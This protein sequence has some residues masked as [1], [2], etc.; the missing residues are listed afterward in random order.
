MTEKE[1]KT[2]KKTP[3]RHR[4]RK[5]FLYSGILLL[6][7]LTGAGAGIWWLTQTGSG[8]KWLMEKVNSMLAPK[9]GEAG[10]NIRLTGLSGSLPFNFRTSLEILDEKGVWLEAPEIVFSLNWHELPKIIHIQALRLDHVDFMRFPE[11]NAEEEEKKPS[12]PFTMEDLQ[13][14]LEKITDFLNTE[15]WWLP[16]IKLENTGLANLQLPSGILPQEGEKRLSLNMEIGAAFKQ[17]Q[18]DADVTLNIKTA[19][20]DAIALPQIELDG[21]NA[22]LGLDIKPEN[23]GLLATSALNIEVLKP[24]LHVA[25]LPP[26]FIGKTS[27]LDLG[28][29]VAASDLK[30]A[31]RLDMA[32]KGPMLTAGNAD[33]SA[34]G[35]WEKNLKTPDIDGPLKYELNAA[36]K[37]LAAGLEPASPLEIIKAP[38]HVHLLLNGNLPEAALELKADCAELARDGHSLKDLTISV[39]TEPVK[40]PLNE[41]GLAALENENKIRVTL[42]A[43]A[44]NN[45]IR[46]A[47][48]LFF[49]ALPK[50]SGWKAGLHD[51]SLDALGMTAAGKLAALLE[52]EKKPAIS[53]NINLNIVNWNVINMFVPDYRLSGKV[54]LDAN[55][56]YSADPAKP[57][58]ANSQNAQV[59]LEVPELALRSN[60][61]S[62]IEIQGLGVNASLADLFGAP[63]FDCALTLRNVKAA[64][65]N[66]GAKI[67]ANGPI[68]G[69]I[70]ADIATSGNVVSRI[71]AKW[72]QGSV[73]ISTLNV[74]AQLP[75]FGKK[76]LGI[77]SRS[78]FSVSYGEKGIQ[79]NG[80]DVSVIPSGRL[81]ADGSLSPVKLD[82]KIR[83]SALDF[84]PWQAL[85]P[86]IPSGSADISVDLS[87][88]PARPSGNFSLK[89]VK[90]K[91]PGV[92]IAPVGATLAGNIENA[93]S[94]SALKINLDI[95]KSTLKTL[96]S[97]GANV[98]GRIPLI[99][100]ADGIPKPDMN[101]PLEAKIRWDGALGPIW[102]LLPIPDRRLNGRIAINIDAGGTLST[103][104]VKGGVKI[105]RARYEDLL[106]GVLLTDINL[107]LNL[108]E[109]GSISRIKEGGGIP[110]KMELAL[111]ASDGRKGSI[112][113]NG[114]GA[115]TGQDL[116]IRAKIDHLK[117]LRRRDI[118][119]ELSGDARVTGTAF[120]PDVT[121]EIVVNQGEVLLNNIDFAGSV[122]TLNITTP[123]ELKKI[124]A[125]TQAVAPKKSEKGTGS[126]N[127]RINMLPRFV[128]E[129]RGL[130]STWRANMRVEGALT[131][132]KILGNISSVQGNFDFLGKVFTLTRGIVFFGGGS[133]S[134][135]L[136]DIELT[137]DAPDLVAHILITGPVDK[138]KLTLTSEPQLPRDEILS[139]VL[140]GKSINDLSRLEMLQLAAAVAQLAGFGSTGGIL[141]SAKKALGVDVLRIGSS[142]GSE[143]E[144]GE[145]TAEGTTI[146]MGKYIN[147]MIYMGVQQGLNPDST[148]FIIQI[149]LTPRTSLEIKTEHN[150]TS[151][152]IKWK[153]NY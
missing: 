62:P 152:G 55:L 73:D 49:Q 111:S 144:P 27:T 92:Q 18:A 105:E 66:I 14:L 138:I 74:E 116:D 75:D 16:E 72:E 80:L 122:T 151:G 5:F 24:V 130:T 149:E 9:A 98:S 58:T 114:T 123:E 81:K 8:H 22:R 65:M 64:G 25:G 10:I 133:P 67:N 31:P 104:R 95:D 124:K 150:N 128:V 117:P 137:N 79:I 132:P 83:L 47:S 106:L 28:M 41:A 17:P 107:A 4:I 134:N 115:L 59:L 1:E 145:E 113:V 77:R 109:N 110:G 103:P 38:L 153:Y 93:G 99:F 21:I 97:N 51:L 129:G 140:F 71:T 139:A 57:Q 13:S 46:L 26:D 37:P 91:V 7:T 3:K 36:L 135:P 87:G 136:L 148:A 29:A 142:S 112:S 70:S 121:G 86:Q 15:H 53:G 48:D 20:G 60:N 96:G 120:A 131:D 35:S 90:V 39:A 101:A 108:T 119:I 147:D 85:V 127:V 143:G 125:E 100:G 63:G 82:L 88:T 34:E 44:D 42:D 146:E 69:P 54:K 126:L 84:K 102:N 12:E 68:S 2:E 43:S 56:D 52:K 78:P 94:L 40:L 118:H 45:P 61:A 76:P 11:M 6:L 50:E 141:N 23:S 89:L 32:I 33:I 19:A 30:T